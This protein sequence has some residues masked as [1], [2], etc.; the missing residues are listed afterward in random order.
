MASTSFPRRPGDAAGH[1]VERL[2]TSLVSSGTAVRILAPH[3]PGSPRE[4]FV[5]GVPITRLPYF[6]PRGLQ[7][8]AYGAGIPS[9]LRHRPVAWLNLPFFLATFFR[10]LAVAGRRHRLI[11]AHWG[12]LGALAVWSRP[13]H[14]RPVVVT[15]HGS[16]LHEGVAPAGVRR[17]TR[18]AVR[19][20]DA[21]LTPSP[22]FERLCNSYGARYCRF[23]PHGVDA[24]PADALNTMVSARGERAGVAPIRLIAVGRL[25]PERGQDLLLRALADVPPPREGG[26]VV[27]V[28]EGPERSRLE[29]RAGRIG[30]AWTVRLTG[31]LAREEVGALLA[32][33]DL[34]VSATSVETFG[35]ATAEAAAAALPIITTPVGYAAELLGAEGALFVEPGAAED[36]RLAVGGLLHDPVR[37]RELGIRARERFDGAALSWDRT[38]RRTAAVYDVVQG[39]R[40][41]TSA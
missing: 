25:V 29:A 27:I 20:A 2:A 22:E 5:D 3:D 1:F 15:V 30:P 11:H 37:R 9:N 19:R 24:P 28:G 26:E 18:F 38:A 16:D 23:V 10:A 39:D 13:L 41:G 35:L 7:R 32:T 8:L 31:Q 12:V 36:L 14:G 33:A 21:V 4:S 40:G 17:L 6:W 34:Y